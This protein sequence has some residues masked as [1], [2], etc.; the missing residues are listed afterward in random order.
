M[1]L[2]IYEMTQSPKKTRNERGEKV[3]SG[4]ITKYSSSSFS[5]SSLLV[6]VCALIKFNF[7]SSHQNPRLNQSSLVKP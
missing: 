1:P 5:H 4:V 2:K 6:F 3:K 7:N